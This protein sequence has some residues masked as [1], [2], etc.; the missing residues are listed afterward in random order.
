[1]ESSANK[2]PNPETNDDAHRAEH[3]NAA[4]EAKIDGTSDVVE[5]V[6]SAFH[7]VCRV[8]QKHP[9]VWRN[10]FY[11]A[12]GDAFRE[13]RFM[14]EWREGNSVFFTVQPTAAF[15]VYSAHTTEAVNAKNFIATLRSFG[16]KFAENYAPAFLGNPVDVSIECAMAAALE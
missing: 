3:P 6:G 1:M 13:K 11:K 2:A 15:G 12:F 9:K 7:L 8:G 14:A 4:R 16:L 5:L 10:R